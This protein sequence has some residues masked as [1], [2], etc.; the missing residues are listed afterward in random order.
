MAKAVMLVAKIERKN[1]IEPTAR[2]ARKKSS[3]LALRLAKGQAADHPDDNQVNGD[4]D[5]RN[6]ERSPFG[7]LTS[8]STFS[9]CFGQANLTSTAIITAARIE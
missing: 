6:H 8:G 2:L 5:D 1:T 4:D 7:S 3:V 9:R